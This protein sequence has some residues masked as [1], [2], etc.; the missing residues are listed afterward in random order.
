MVYD[1]QAQ[2]SY[3][4][5]NWFDDLEDPADLEGEGFAYIID[6]RNEKLFF[7]KSGQLNVSGGQMT[8]TGKY[9]E[10]SASLFED[11]DNPTF[12][13]VSGFGTMGCN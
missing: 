12:R 9:L 4:I 7:S 8:F 10:I 13:E 3:N 2:G 6:F 5:I 1:K 11:E